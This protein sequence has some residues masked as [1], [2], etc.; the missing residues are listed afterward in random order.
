MCSD[1][2]SMSVGAAGRGAWLE[3]PSPEEP[4]P[5]AVVEEQGQMAQEADSSTRDSPVTVMLSPDRVT[6]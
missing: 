4:R 2:I 3:R 6:T 1:T 5:Q